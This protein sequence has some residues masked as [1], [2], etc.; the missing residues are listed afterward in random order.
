MTTAAIA[1]KAGSR[2]GIAG[3]LMLVALAEA[4][5]VGVFVA[6]SWLSLIHDLQSFGGVTPF[7]VMGGFVV[8]V[9]Q[10]FNAQAEAR[11]TFVKDYLS[12]FYL[13]E[14]LSKAWHELIYSYFDE[15]YAKAQAHVEAGT[16]FPPTEK[17]PGDYPFWH[18]TAKTFYGSDAERRL[19]VVFGYFDVVGFYY[20]RGLANLDD[21][22]DVLG[23]VFSV[24]EARK[25]TRDYFEVIEQGWQHPSPEQPVRRP[26]VYLDKLRGDVRGA[27]ATAVRGAP[28]RHGNRGVVVSWVMA[29]IALAAPGLIALLGYGSLDF[30]H[31]LSWTL[32]LA[33]LWALSAMVCVMTDGWRMLPLVAGAAPLTLFWPLV[34]AYL[35]RSGAL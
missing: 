15:E 9:I 14:E 6:L 7:L 34:L 1:H 35:H 5:L 2:I 26:F 20:A 25:A 17:R 22:A 24:V 4:V 3:M 27:T 19:D 13:H 28:R 23:Y 31:A 11:S 32:V 21:I 29:G 8:T 16:D 18:P 30:L 33:A 10:L 12:Q